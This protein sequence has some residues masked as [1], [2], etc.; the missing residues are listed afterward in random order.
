MNN[1]LVKVNDTKPWQIS[2]LSDGTLYSEIVCFTCT[3]G[4][5]ILKY[6]NWKISLSD[7]SNS[8]QVK[9]VNND[10]KDKYQPS[11]LTFLSVSDFF[12]L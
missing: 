8:M 11:I 6:D 7:C 2:A 4:H 12:T 1:D 10:M 3:N 9:S 5:E